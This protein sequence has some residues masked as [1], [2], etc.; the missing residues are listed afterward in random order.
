MT[1]SKGRKADTRPP[2]SV[3]TTLSQR[4]FIKTASIYARD[5]KKAVC[6]VKK[7][8]FLNPGSL[9]GE[10]LREATSIKENGRQWLNT[11]NKSYEEMSI[12][13]EIF[14]DGHAKK[15]YSEIDELYDDIKKEFSVTLEKIKKLKVDILKSTL[16]NDYNELKKI[17]KIAQGIKSKFFS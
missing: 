8:S 1:S 13:A 12:N 10:S 17:A 4:L 6:S 11:L 9:T 7:S 14:D 3:K 16:E 5:R 2:S 15:L